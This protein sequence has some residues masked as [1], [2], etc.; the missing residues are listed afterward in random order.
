[1]LYDPADHYEPEETAADFKA[2]S[3]LYERFMNVKKS[4]LLK[5]LKKKDTQS[6]RN[7]LLSPFII[8]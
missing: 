3:K 8:L 4:R 2:H 7:L 1:M 6:K 5:L